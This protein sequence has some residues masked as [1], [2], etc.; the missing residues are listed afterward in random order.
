MR[1]KT[2]QLAAIQPGHNA[3]APDL[4]SVF[5]RGLTRIR[6]CTPTA[7]PLAVLARETD[8]YKIKEASDEKRA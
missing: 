5:F 4:A 8:K 1:E 2:M 3:L 6:A 7:S